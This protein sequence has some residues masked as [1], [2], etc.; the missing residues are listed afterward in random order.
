MKN[1]RED[2]QHAIENS[3]QVT[4]KTDENIGNVRS[5]FLRKTAGCENNGP[6]LQFR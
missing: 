4:P 6:S 3:I 5:Q 1:A 2:G